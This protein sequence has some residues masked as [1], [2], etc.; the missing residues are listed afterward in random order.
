MQKVIF[1]FILKIF[2]L[3][4]YNSE[5]QPT[6]FELAVASAYTA[7]SAKDYVKAGRIAKELTKEFPLKPDPWVVLGLLHYEDNLP[8]LAMKFLTKAEQYQDDLLYFEDRIKIFEL[9]AAIHQKINEFNLEIN[10]LK[11]IT[12][13]TSGRK[14]KFYQEK[15]SAAFYRLGIIHYQ[16]EK[17]P[18]AL[19]FFLQAL[20]ANYRVPLI[21]Y[22]FI[23]HYYARFSQQ[24]IN[25][26]FSNYFPKNYQV[27]PEKRNSF[28]F[29]YRIYRNLFAENNNAFLS[30]PTY[31]K[32]HEE[33]QNFYFSLAQN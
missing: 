21:P 27:I 4:S 22:L 1:V 31:K 7:L 13:L 10:D 20:E 19:D 26:Q 17:W 16:I 6:N 14:G 18:E 29:Y 15:A 5:V 25:L 32:M 9:K 12:D 8:D 24:E 23:T 33:I 3:F 2:F 11:K 28:I 30:D